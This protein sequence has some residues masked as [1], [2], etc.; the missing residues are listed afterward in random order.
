MWLPDWVDDLLEQPRR[1]ILYVLIAVVAGVW[2]PPY[3]VLTHRLDG[4]WPWWAL[5]LI[6]LGGGY[7]I[8]RIAV[9]PLTVE[10]RATRRGRPWLA[11]RMR[12]VCV[13]LGTLATGTQLGAAVAFVLAPFTGQVGLMVSAFLLVLYGMAVCR[14][15]DFGFSGLSFAIVGRG[16]SG[17]QFRAGEGPDLM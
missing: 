15:A 17:I 13:C 1:R 4:G 10:L 8:S 6:T 16:G 3:L 12:T 2:W 9:I 7:I 11:R 5:L 14:N